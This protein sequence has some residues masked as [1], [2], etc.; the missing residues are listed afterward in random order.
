MFA[1]ITDARDEDAVA[2]PELVF[3]FTAEVIAEV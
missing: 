1:L 2:I 3:E